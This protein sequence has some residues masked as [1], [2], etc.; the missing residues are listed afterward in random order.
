MLAINIKKDKD[1]GKI[2][3]QHI[4]I[5]WSNLIL[6]KEALTHTKINKS[7]HSLLGDGPPKNKIKVNDD[8]NI[9]EP[10][11]LKKK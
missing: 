8:I 4:V 6:G 1:K 3:I 10:Y 7:K 2:L 11:S 5:N 9:I